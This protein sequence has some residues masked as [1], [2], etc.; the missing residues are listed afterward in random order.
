MRMRLVDVATRVVIGGGVIVVWTSVAGIVVS[1]SLVLA[2]AAMPWIIVPVVGALAV[3]LRRRRWISSVFAGGVVV[4][5]VAISVPAVLAAEPPAWSRG[6][7][8]FTLF[9]ANVFRGNAEASEAFAAVLAVD[10][11]V[12][13][14]NEVS[15]ELDGPLLG[16]GLLR[17]YPTVVRSANG[18]VIL[19]RLRVV[20]R[21]VE[22]GCPM[23][24]PSL[25]ISLAGREV[26]LI[27]VH[28]SA[29]TN[30]LA[31][32]R[33]SQELLQVG[34]VGRSTAGRDVVIAGDFNATRFHG[35]FASLV[36]EGFVDAHDHVGRGLVPSWG[37]RGIP[38][39]GDVGVFRLDHA[40]SRGS[41]SPLRVADLP[42]PGSDHVGFLVTYAVRPVVSR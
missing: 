21:G 17:R 37:P 32:E 19:S 8:E 41:L 18:G 3:S 7:P 40:L 15:D 11:D 33:W 26:E 29:P 9:A 22:G 5:T 35:P 30:W 25:T 34:A 38:L 1:P 10:A 20:R 6:A 31:R 14:L 42:I 2:Q 27:A 13:V 16:S 39:F 28:T 12:V 23:S 4:A 24:L 36:D